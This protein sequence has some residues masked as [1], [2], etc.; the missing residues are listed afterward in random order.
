MSLTADD[1]REFVE[2]DPENDERE[3]LGDAL[4]AVAVDCETDAVKTIRT[5]C[6]QP[7]DNYT[8]CSPSSS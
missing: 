7:S 2:T 8:I 5:L 6:G 3:P 4:A 1:F